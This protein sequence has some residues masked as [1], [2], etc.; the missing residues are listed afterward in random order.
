[1]DGSVLALAL[2]FIWL[3]LKIFN[4]FILLITG[5]ATLVERVTHTCV[6]FQEK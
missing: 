6:E 5:T 1:M 2:T 4:N 3:N